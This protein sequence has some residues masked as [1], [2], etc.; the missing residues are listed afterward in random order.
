MLSPLPVSF[1]LY[2]YKIFEQV[3]SAMQIGFF[4]I[5]NLE[6]PGRSITATTLFSICHTAVSF[7]TEIPSG[8]QP[9]SRYLRLPI[10][11]SRRFVFPL[12]DKDTYVSEWNRRTRS[13][14]FSACSPV[15][16]G[17]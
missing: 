14:L 12:V 13:V 9:R 15:G 6:E 16:Y 1:V 5:S 8:G 17:S 11:S 4:A 3:T 2:H 7:S 10:V